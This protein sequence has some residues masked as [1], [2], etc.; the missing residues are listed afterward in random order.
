MVAAAVLSA[1]VISCDR[2]EFGAFGDDDAGFP[3]DVYE[4]PNPSAAEL[5]A[6]RRAATEALYELMED[7][8]IPSGPADQRNAFI[9]T[10]STA[11]GD[12]I[13]I[14]LDQAPAGSVAAYTKYLCKPPM[15]PDSPEAKRLLGD[16]SSRLEELKSNPELTNVDF[17]AAAAEMQD[18][19]HKHAVIQAVMPLM[20]CGTAIQ[21]D[22]PIDVTS[23]KQ[24]QVS[25]VLEAWIVEGWALLCPD[26]APTAQ[27][28]GVPGPH[29]C[30]TVPDKN[31]GQVFT[32]ATSIACADALDLIGRYL[33]DPRTQRG[34]RG[35]QMG[36]W[37]CNILGAAEAEE[38]GYFIVCNNDAGMVTV[39][40]VN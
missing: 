12:Q 5:Q 23:V 36:E 17:D 40:P 2:A 38:L 14:A 25:P 24:A 11:F 18:I 29:D 20:V 9:E 8:G 6:S 37:G 33:D 32:E 13:A 16:M 7:S 30:G 28:V 35:A 21:N 27:D 22:E 26:H 34:D 39:R 15:S 3:C 4:G 10:N 31:T 1:G 19:N